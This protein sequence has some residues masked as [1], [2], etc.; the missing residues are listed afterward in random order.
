MHYKTTVEMYLKFVE[1]RKRNNKRKYK[2]KLWFVWKENF[3]FGIILKQTV[4]FD[5][6]CSV[7]WFV[8]YLPNKKYNWY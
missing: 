2:I 4:T 6:V 3:T 5:I 1:K 7:E 8:D